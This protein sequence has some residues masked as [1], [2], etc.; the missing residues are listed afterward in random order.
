MTASTVAVMPRAR[1]TDA[2]PADPQGPSAEL[3]RF[4]RCLSSGASPWTPI[5]ELLWN[6]PNE[7]KPPDFGALGGREDFKKLLAKVEAR[8][9]A[10]AAKKEAESK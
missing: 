7:L 5:T 8:T 6:V 3:A 9:K 2:S 1:Q 4:G 10:E